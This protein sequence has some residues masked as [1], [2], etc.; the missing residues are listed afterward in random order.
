M[1]DKAVTEVLERYGPQRVVEMAKTVKLPAELGSAFGRL[2]TPEWDAFLLPSFLDAAETGAI[3]LVRGYLWARYFAASIIWARPLDL[4]R[5]TSAQKGLFFS[6]LPFVADVW[7]LAEERLGGDIAEYWSQVRPNPYQAQ[8]DILEAAETALANQR[9]EIAVDCLNA[10]KHKNEKFPASLAT[11]AI[12]QLI[13]NATAVDRVD[14]HHLLELIE[15]L[16]AAADANVADV[17]WIEFQ[18]LK[19]L[20]WLS[21]GTPVF[22]ERRLATDPAFFHE[23]ITICFLSERERNEPNEPDEERRAMAGQVFGLLHN[24]Q[25]PPAT[26][27]EQ[28]IDQSAFCEWLAEVRRLCEDSG[29]WTI[30]QQMI[31]QSLIHSPAGLGGILNYPSV[32]KCLDAPEHEHMRRGFTL[33]LFNSRGVHGFTGGKEE[34]ELARHYRGHA[35]KFDLAKFTRIATSLRGLA[36]GYER[37]AER[38]ARRD[39]FEE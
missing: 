20:I 23:V 30:A 7:R 6:S 8:D 9:P 14:R 18:C 19:L 36:E 35:E 25:T 2:G 16:Q 34:L 4:S 15:H 31:G 22:L 13:T 37:D 1:R 33:A 29:H 21:G 28:S 27:P 5:W 10:L 17:A 12:K 24:W 11:A 32:A 3:E 38:E 39:P 26:T